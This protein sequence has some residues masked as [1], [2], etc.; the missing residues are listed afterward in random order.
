MTFCLSNLFY[1]PLVLALVFTCGVFLFIISH[2]IDMF[3][4]LLRRKYKVY[5]AI[6]ENR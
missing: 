6:K 3:I 2:L 4:N 5:K 1:I